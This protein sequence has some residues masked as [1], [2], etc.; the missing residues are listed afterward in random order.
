MTKNIILYFEDE[1]DFR[2]AAKRDLDRYFPAYKTIV[3]EG[4]DNALRADLTLT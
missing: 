3:Q 1:E 2:E 4:Q